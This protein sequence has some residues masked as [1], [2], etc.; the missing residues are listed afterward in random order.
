MNVYLDHNST[1][2]LDQR[3][4][5]AM[6]PYLQNHFGNPSSSHYEGAIAAQAVDVARHRVAN[7]VGADAGD[8]IFCSTATEAINAVIG[9]VPNGTIVISQ[10]EHSATLRA[11]DRA[12]TNGLRIIKLGVDRNGQINIPEFH[13]CLER[14]RP[15]L[16]SF[17]WANNETGVIFPIEAISALC[18]A[19]GVLLHVDGAQ[20]AG[21]LSI[22][23]QTLPIDFL[24]ISAHKFNGPKGAAALIKRRSAGLAPL[25]VGGQQEHGLRAGTE[26]VAGIV[27][28][29]VAS[30]IAAADHQ[31]RWNAS[32]TV[33]D[34]FETRVLSQ[35]PGTWVNGCKSPRLS[36]TTNI[37]FDGID[38]DDLCSALSGLGIA[39]STGSA[40]QSS[41]TEPSHVIKAMTRSYK[42]AK[43]SLRFSFSHLTT[44]NEM[45]HV[46]D[47]VVLVVNSMRPPSMSMI[48]SYK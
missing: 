23:L 41:S 22:D 44:Q 4:L 24:T 18:G 27:G 35:V 1:T 39:T 9:S 31:I 17:I 38:A 19:A 47:T 2:P 34:A 12:Q 25:I 29:G 36:N 33:R 8:V 45:Q 20:A 10:V 16:V 28:F 48:N 11:A 37:G 21:K 15:S 30:G 46:A 40:C 13:T 42:A 3:V 26:N 32:G 14:E 7:L 5:D 43:S 6:L